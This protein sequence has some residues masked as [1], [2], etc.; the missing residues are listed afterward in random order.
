MSGYLIMEEPEITKIHRYK[1]TSM[2]SQMPL[3]DWLYYSL[4]CIYSVVDGV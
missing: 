4:Q 1:F 2:L 3:S